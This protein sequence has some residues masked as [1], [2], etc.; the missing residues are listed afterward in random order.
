MTKNSLGILAAALLLSPLVAACGSGSSPSASATASALAVADLSKAQREAQD[1]AIDSAE[2]AGNDAV[3]ATVRKGSLVQL[4]ADASELTVLIIPQFSGLKD[5]A[6]AAMA[7][8]NKSLGI[9]SSDI[10]TRILA[11]VADDAT[12]RQS[13][14]GRGVRIEWWP[15]TRG[16]T[17]D[18][19]VKWQKL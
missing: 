5:A 7:C 11:T 13:F 14:D 4:S 2:A 15:E 8:A 18:T 19:Y 16:A 9:D 1:C 6:S 10:A 12:Q 17:V 3:L